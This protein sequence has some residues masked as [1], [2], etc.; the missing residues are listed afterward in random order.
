[1]GNLYVYVHVHYSR[2]NNLACADHTA[3]CKLTELEFITAS[4]QKGLS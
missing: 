2:S 1:M 4:N 3:L